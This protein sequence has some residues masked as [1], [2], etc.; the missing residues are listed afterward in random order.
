MV[1]KMKI[2]QYGQ[3]TYSSQDIFEKLY[4]NA[5]LCIASV[6]GEISDSDFEK[7]NQAIDD[8]LL[9]LS[10]IDF[11]TNI[12]MSVEQFDTQN[13]HNWYMPEEFKNINVEQFIHALCETD[14][15]HERVTKELILYKERDMYNILRFMIYLVHF[16]TENNIVWGVGRGSSVA[17]YCLYLIGIHKVNSIKYN[18]FIEEFLR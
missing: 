16:M 8:E 14:E 5:D 9:E 11:P 2:D 1:E 13:Q 15:E 17:S 7:H 18:L 12:D 4:Q 10:K 6:L 3:V